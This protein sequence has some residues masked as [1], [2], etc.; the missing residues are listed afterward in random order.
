MEPMITPPPV[1]RGSLWNKRDSSSGNSSS[2][3]DTCGYLS[4]DYGMLWKT[5]LLLPLLPFLCAL[6]R[7][8]CCSPLTYLLLQASPLTCGSGYT[9]STGPS[10]FPSHLGCCN[11]VDC[12]P[13]SGAHTCIT[14]ESG[15]TPCT[16][17]SS[18]YCIAQY[19][20]LLFWY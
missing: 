7:N 2:A 15:T 10:L 17:S 6:D 11:A 3:L 19:T 13:S 20:S 18:T 8:S 12:A 14:A 16:S 9:C 1:L 4:G 5:L